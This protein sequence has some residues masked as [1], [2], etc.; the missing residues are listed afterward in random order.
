M[1]PVQQMINLSK[2]GQLPM[3]S[4][5]A[6]ATN[7]RAR[8]QSQNQHYRRK[9]NQA[10]TG[11]YYDLRKQSRPLYD[12]VEHQSAAFVNRDMTSSTFEPFRMRHSS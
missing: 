6:S 3:M 12:L 8:V 11:I 10:A 7:P 2:R 4:S 1:D 9:M 5:E